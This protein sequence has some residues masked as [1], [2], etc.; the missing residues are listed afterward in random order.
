M[1]EAVFTELQKEMEGS[2]QAFRK[3]LTKLRTGRASTALL[4]GIV[5]EYYGTQ[6]P[7]NQV[8]TLGAPEPRLL[9]VQPYDRS[10]M[11]N[12]EKAILKSDLGLTPNNDGKVIRIPIPAL[13]EERRRD[14][15]KHVKKS[16]E[17]FR[18]SVRNHRRLAIEKLKEM[19]KKKEATADDVKHGQ[20]RIQKM[21]NDYV[22]KI[23]KALAGKEAEIMEV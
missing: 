8:A 11:A 9:V 18:V 2:L 6:T 1:N 20:D 19:E 7:L 10:I 23:D 5:V 15:V 12:I 13:T 21:T 3:E 17:E 14:L 16:A 4:E 22:E